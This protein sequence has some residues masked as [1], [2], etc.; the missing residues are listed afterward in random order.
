MADTDTM[1]GAVYALMAELRPLT[2]VEELGAAVV[3]VNVTVG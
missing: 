3:A 2:S 1:M